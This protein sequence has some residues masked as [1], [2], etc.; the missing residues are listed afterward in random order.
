METKVYVNDAIAKKW[1]ELAMKRFG[2]GRGSISRAAQEALAMWIENEESI[3]G[4][5]RRLVG[6]ATKEKSIEA[7]FLFGSY[8]RKE[9]YHDVDIAIVISPNADRL[10]LLQ[11][12]EGFTPDFPRFDLSLFNDMPLNM[13]SKALSECE[14]IYVRQGFD[15]KGLTAEVMQKWVD[16]KPMLTA[17]L[18]EK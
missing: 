8:A 1:K 7:L 14:V 9:P 4:A 17:P 10:G 18:V 16:L 13:K 2:Y 11:K 3:D 5:L 15:I 12:L 6:F